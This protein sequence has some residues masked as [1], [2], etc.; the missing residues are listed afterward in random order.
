MKGVITGGAILITEIGRGTRDDLTEEP[1]AP[2]CRHRC[3]HLVAA[4]RGGGANSR[5][6]RAAGLWA[7]G[8][9]KG[10]GRA[11]VH[12]GE[13]AP[14]A[15]R[16]RHQTLDQGARGVEGCLAFTLHELRHTHATILLRAGTPVHIV[17]K[18]LGHKDPSVTLNVYADVIPEDDLN[19]VQIFSQTV[20]GGLAN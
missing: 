9:A 13:R 3:P 1:R 18:R 5:P 19:A 14:A 17:S 16:L 6:P 11:V 20:W 15:A 8:L 4:V 2:P 10:H 12:L 7:T